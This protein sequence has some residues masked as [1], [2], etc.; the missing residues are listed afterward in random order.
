MNPANNINYFFLNQLC[1]YAQLGR[2]QELMNLGLPPEQ[3]QPLMNMTITQLEAFSRELGQG[4]IA[5]NSSDFLQRLA[6]INIPSVCVEFIAHGASKE[7]MREILK[8]SY[9]EST[10][11]RRFVD[12]QPDY[13]QRSIPTD[14]YRAMWNDIELLP[15]PLKPTAEE[16]LT[17]SKKYGVGI[18]AIWSD[19]KNGEV[20]GK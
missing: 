13:K 10:S 19:I 8:I 7:V 17:L 3:I 11:W 2:E 4:F 12:T 20:N 14:C 1:I 16:L 18:G 6:Q 9:K 5:I 15:S